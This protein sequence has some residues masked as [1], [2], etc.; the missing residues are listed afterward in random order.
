[1]VG[2]THE[3]SKMKLTFIAATLAVLIWGAAPALAGPV[4]ACPEGGP[5][6]DSDTVADCNDNCSEEPNPDQYDADGDDCGNRCDGDFDQNGIVNVVDLSDIVINGYGS[7]NGKYDV[8]TPHD[9]ATGGVTTVVDL[10][11]EI[12][13]KYG[14]VPGPSGT[15]SG[16]TA[17]PD[18]P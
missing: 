10:S 5:D 8:Q 3:E 14:T 1:M 12:L 18:T 17:C 7:T 15:T 9:T 13:N 2:A 11:D 4:P 6:F 16:T